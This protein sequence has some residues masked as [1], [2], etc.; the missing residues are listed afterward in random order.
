[1]QSTMTPAFLLMRCTA[2]VALAALLS[3]CVPAT[4]RRVADAPLR[5]SVEP[6]QASDDLMLKLLSAQFALQDGDIAAAARGFGEASRLS[7]DHALAEE[8]T[9]LALALKDWPLATQALARWQALAP[10]EPGVV[11]ARAWIALGAGRDEE[12]LAALAALAE[13]GDDQGWRLVAQALL[14]AQD[15]ARA[16]KLLDAL[17]V[18]RLQVAADANLVALSQLA[19]KLGDKA[20]ARRIVD[21]AMLR[22]HSA[23]GAI[24]SAR[25]AVDA[26]DKAGARATYAAAIARDGKNVRL[27]SAYAALLGEGGDNAGAARVLADGP[28]DD[29]LYAARAAYA[30]RADDKVLLSALYRE[31]DADRSAR[32]GTRLFLLGQVA[33]LTGRRE[34][35]LAW[36]HE[37]PEDDEHAFE[38]RMRA[39]LVLDQLDRTGEAIDALHRLAEVAAGDG[40]QQRDVWLLEAEI[41]V[42]R[43]R[44]AEAGRVYDRALGILP[45]DPRLLYARAL[46]AVDRGDVAAGERD[47]RRVIELKPDDA[48]ALN[49]LGY[50]LADHNL[51]GD[52]RQQ[53]ALALIERALKLKPD[54]PAIIDSMGWVRY[55][56]GELDASLENLRRAYAKQPDADIAA[57][58][59]EVLWASG[60]RDEARRVWDEGRRKDAKNK[61]LIETMRRLAQ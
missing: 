46:L 11:Q 31:L 56:L 48:E 27:R 42:R 59:G 23:D 3:A 34:A 47:L 24:W 53:E 58:L 57:H 29:T 17:V 36:Y 26:G 44:Q 8:A 2:M 45:D 35:A 18:P 12:A 28:Q 21:V 38:A 49:A 43:Q 10:K 50:T 5:A 25:L 6:V 40:E 52:P 13:R 22:F 33:E 20:L 1:M 54:E 7:D 30:A 60:E 14:N 15:K 32:D 9:R 4:M 39:A 41:L 61:A 55:R 37:V 51:R 19:F 16:A